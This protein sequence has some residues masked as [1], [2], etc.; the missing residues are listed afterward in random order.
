MEPA[1]ELAKQLLS[2]AQTGEDGSLL[3]AAHHAM[4]QTLFWLGQCI[5]AQTHLELS[6]SLY[7]PARYPSHAVPYF[8]VDIAVHS[9]AISMVNLWYLGFSDKARSTADRA[10]ALA[11]GF[12]PPV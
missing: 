3:P 10:V 12:S 4:G 5:S 7:D 9:L 8:G 1:L 11:R 2:V 6:R